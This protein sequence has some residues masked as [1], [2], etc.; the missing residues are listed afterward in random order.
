MFHNDI[1]NVSWIE[2]KKMEL[3]ENMSPVYLPY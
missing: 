3:V 2:K 1:V